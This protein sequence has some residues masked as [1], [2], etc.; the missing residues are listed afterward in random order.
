[1]FQIVHGEEGNSKYKDSMNDVREA[2]GAFR[3]SSYLR[4]TGVWVICADGDGE[5]EDQSLEGFCTY[6]KGFR[7]YSA[8]DEELLRIVSRRMSWLVV[9]L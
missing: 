3:I 9:I 1:M 6:C 7:F 8:G 5:A 2:C 4:G